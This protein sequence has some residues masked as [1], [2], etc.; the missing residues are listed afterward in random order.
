MLA[1]HEH[2]V[3]L[4]QFKPSL[5]TADCHVLLSHRPLSLLVDD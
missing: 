2:K 5:S 4:I 1:L 3:G